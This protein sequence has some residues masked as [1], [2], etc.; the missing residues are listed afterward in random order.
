MKL[1]SKLLEQIAYNTRPNLEEH[2]LVVLDKRTHEDHLS[3]PLKTNN[4]Q[5]KIAVTFS[6]GYNGIFKVTNSNNNVF[7]KNQ[8]VIK[9]VIY[10]LP[11]P[12]VL[13]NSKI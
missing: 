10:K 5:F 4:K 2:L 1:A 8:F 9:M 7:S 3:Q 13:K 12:V 11:Y 6:T